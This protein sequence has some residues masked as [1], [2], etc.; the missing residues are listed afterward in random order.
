MSHDLGARL[1]VLFLSGWRLVTFKKKKK[2][3]LILCFLNDAPFFWSA[4][5]MLTVNIDWCNYLWTNTNRVPSRRMNGRPRNCFNH[6][7]QQ[8]PLWPQSPGQETYY[9][10]LMSVWHFTRTNCVCVE[11]HLQAKWIIP[12]EEHHSAVSPNFLMCKHP[13]VSVLSHRC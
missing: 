13:W 9:T 10:S 11:I 3:S 8:P 1:A 6:N 5:Q 4:I 7:R 12:Q 2:L